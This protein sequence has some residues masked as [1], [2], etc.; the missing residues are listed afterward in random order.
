MAPPR[1]RATALVDD[2]RSEASSGTREL[3]GTGGKGKKFAGSALAA[4]AAASRDSRA[5]TSV[6]SAPVRETADHAA[7][8]PVRVR[9]T[10]T[11]KIK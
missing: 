1:Q 9:W 4:N 11:K 7:G 3:K 6:T 8:D 5:A 2:S 10:A